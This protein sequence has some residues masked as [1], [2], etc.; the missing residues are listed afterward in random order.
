MRDVV[1]Q[2]SAGMSCII[3]T[4]ASLYDKRVPCYPVTFTTFILHHQIRQLM[5]ILHRG[6]AAALEN[7]CVCVLTQKFSK[8]PD[9]ELIAR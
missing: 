6:S 3:T 4:A 1:L 5:A 9:D 2:P 8:G 7:A